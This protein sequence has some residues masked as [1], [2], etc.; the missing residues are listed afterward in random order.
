M[1]KIET[2]YGLVEHKSAIDL[3]FFFISRGEKDI[4][5]A[6][7]Y[8]FVQ[9]LYGQNVFNLGFGD[10]D[11]ECDSIVDNV[12]SNNGDA[13]RVLNT[14]LHSIPI[15]FK[16][17]TDS[18]LMVQGS[19]GRPSFIDI[20]RDTCKKKCIVECKNYKR[21]I[22]IYRA[23]VDKNYHQLIIDYQF[24]GGIVNNPQQIIL[25]KYQRYKNY[26]S[27]FLTKKIHKFTV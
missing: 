12:N 2:T 23:Y 5:K 22:N 13:Y 9:E 7:Q 19:D 20:C 18:V 15:F 17:F 21:R 4:V 11:V 25:E 27:V 16:H 26:D 14:V 8:S 10:Y 24:L 6:I 3:K 1:S